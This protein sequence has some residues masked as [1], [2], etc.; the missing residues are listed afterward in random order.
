[1]E[2]DEIHAGVEMLSADLTEHIQMCIDALIP[3]AEELG[4]E[5]R[6]G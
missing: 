6:G 5:G 1:M 4:L 2:R 3:H